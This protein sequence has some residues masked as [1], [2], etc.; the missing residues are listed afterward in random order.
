MSTQF[1]NW[2]RRFALISTGLQPGDS[3][4]LACSSRFSGFRDGGKAVETAVLLATI[5]H[6]AEARC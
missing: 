2:L 1:Q 6:R 4:R 5:Q 3:W